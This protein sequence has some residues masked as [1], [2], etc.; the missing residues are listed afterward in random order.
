[1]TSIVYLKLMPWQFVFILFVMKNKH[2]YICVHCIC[3]IVQPVT[4]WVCSICTE[5][6]SLMESVCVLFVLKHIPSRF[7]CAVLMCFL[8]GA[9]FNC[10]SLHYIFAEVHIL[11]ICVC[12]LDVLSLHWGAQFDGISVHY[13]YAEVRTLTICVCCRSTAR[14]NAVCRLT[15]CKS[16]LA[17][18]WKK[19]MTYEKPFVKSVSYCSVPNWSQHP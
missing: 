13:S 17:F 8:W 7:V 11:T 4:N 10:I 3:V 2:W 5:M 15:F 12:C 1:M 14:C 18:P 6:H 19:I 9:Q 16:M